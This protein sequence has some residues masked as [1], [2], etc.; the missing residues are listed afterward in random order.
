MDLRKVVK[1]FK[2]GKKIF[3][4]ARVVY[5]VYSDNLYRMIWDVSPIVAGQAGT[6][7]ARYHEFNQTLY[8]TYEPQKVFSTD[9][10]NSRYNSSYKFFSVKDESGLKF[11][12]THRIGKEED[13]VIMLQKAFDALNSAEMKQTLD[14]YKTPPQAGT[15]TTF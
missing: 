2:K 9:S 14:N 10:R 6:F 4:K 8:L 1:S 15:S 11:F 3:K 13:I 5:D 7:E 12:H